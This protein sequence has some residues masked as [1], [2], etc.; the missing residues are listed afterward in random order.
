M[1]YHYT[2][3][4]TNLNPTNNERYYIG[5]RSGKVTPESDIKYMSSSN[6]L[7]EDIKK[8]GKVNFEKII[9]KEW[10]SRELAER[11]EIRLHF[12]YDVARNEIFYNKANQLDNGF[13]TYGNI[14]VAKKRIESII[15]CWE[16][17]SA[18]EIS[19]H[20]AIASKISIN[21]WSKKTQQEKDIIFKKVAESNKTTWAN[22]SIEEKEARSKKFK[23]IYNNKSQEEKNI[24]AIRNSKA[25]KGT[26]W[27][28][29]GKVRKRCFLGQ[30][31]AGFIPGHKINV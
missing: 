20:A 22:K 7:H 24:I 4:I 30:E 31:P 19:A 28:T 21:T 5:V 13:T 26:K 6:Y 1:K 3:L 23:E 2:Y 10:A 12:E 25:T 11:H 14:D 16:N 8:F 27:Y 9:I 17:K 18:S 29:N 15:K